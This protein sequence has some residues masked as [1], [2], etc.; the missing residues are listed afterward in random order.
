M[1][2]GVQHI[3]VIIP[4][5]DYGSNGNGYARFANMILCGVVFVA[6]AVWARKLTVSTQKTV[7]DLIKL[8]NVDAPTQ[9]GN[10]DIV[11]TKDNDNIVGAVSAKGTDGLELVNVSAN[12]QTSDKV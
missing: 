10:Y 2:H 3:P 4:G 7:T 5:A 8:L 6:L 12:S 1:N 9:R 11:S